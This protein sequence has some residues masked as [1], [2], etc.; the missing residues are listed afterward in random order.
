M[1]D[2]SPS[3]LILGGG[4]AG[5]SAADY[6]NA[7]GVPVYLVEKAD[8]LGGK[9]RDWACMAT[10]KCRY[11]GACLSV[12]LADRVTR[13]ANVSVLLESAVAKLSR[14]NGR[15]KA[16]VI[17]KAAADLDVD[18]VLVT[19]GMSLFDPTQQSDLGYA[20]YENVITT[21]ELN[22][23]LRQDALKTRLANTA[24][25]A[26]AFIQCVGSRNREQGRDY[27]S[28]VCCKTAVRQ[29]NRIMHA[30]P[31]AA[32]SIFNIDLQATGKEFRTQ[33][34]EAASR[35]ELLQGTPAKIM[36]SVE[37]GKLTVF[38][39]DGLAGRTARHFDLVV[40]AVGIRPASATGEIAGMLG[41]ETDEWGFLGPGGPGLPEGIYTAGTAGGPTGILNAA[42]QGKA[43]ARRI[44]RF[45]GCPP[46]NRKK[47]VAIFGGGNTAARVAAGLAARGYPAAVIAPDDDAGSETP[48]VTRYPSSRLTRVTGTAG[49]YTIRIDTPAG[50]QCIDAGAMVIADQPALRPPAA[51]AAAGQAAITLTDF[52]DRHARQEPL[53][54][55][56]LFWLDHNG[57][58]RKAFVQRI[59]R[60]VPE[61]AA[62]GT[63]VTILMEK[64]LVNYPGGQKV[65]DTVRGLGVKLLRVTD[66]Q[67]V[68]LQ[69]NG[70][71]LILNINEASLPGVTVTA[72]CDLMVVPEEVF[73]SAN[74]REVARRLHQSLDAEGFLQSANV[75]HRN[76]GS[77]RR[78]L[79]Y[80]GF[81]HD[82]ADLEEE[83]EEIGAALELDDR[84]RTAAADR[85]VINEDVCVRCLTCFRLCPHGAISLRDQKQPNIDPA[86]C[87]GCSLCVSN[88]PAVT[89]KAPAHPE[90][91]AGRTVV[92][93]C[94]RSA[95]LAARE[96]TLPEEACL[97][98]VPC[99]CSLE[100]PRVLQPLLDG[101][102]RVVLA[103]CHDGNCRSLRGAAFAAGITQQ[104][105]EMTR[106]PPE[107]LSCIEIAANEPAR[108]EQMMTDTAPAGEEG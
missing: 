3:V 15:F 106:L 76:V 52:L 105:V 46:E 2:S 20:A 55:R 95:A 82:E 74:G 36:N 91:G 70:D 22:A 41:V 107:R 49:N 34:A 73:V 85:P 104:V 56:V 63:R 72:E 21:A 33:L 42:G 58:E 93:A 92:F 45:L 53:P 24:Q 38:H 51:I 81:S 94:Q 98:P 32:V 30:I 5:L 23:I 7:C 84:R 44:T 9:A 61:L 6:L 13:M 102:E 64:M 59:L 12:E 108:L 89:I 14:Q 67:Q 39:E 37:P 75:R 78:G 19:T 68:S 62:A 54:E 101:A 96:A 18:A 100:T 69:P 27:C 79:Y 11:C 28:R 40:L 66:Q 97:V 50:P 57:P 29:A 35:I 65:Y 99:A 48:D 71:R 17:G 83:L 8:H 80:A 31:D 47:T 16:A 88:C 86:A 60:V 10:D 25:P 103:P 77:P 90:T 4:V 1:P 87:L 43:S 26:I